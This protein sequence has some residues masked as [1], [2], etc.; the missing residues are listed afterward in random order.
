[1]NRNRV[2][3][4]LRETK[5]DSKERKPSIRQS[6]LVNGGE[7]AGAVAFVA[8]KKVSNRPT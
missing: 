5:G 7:R 4:S 8:N 2:Q 1:M 6:K 3:T